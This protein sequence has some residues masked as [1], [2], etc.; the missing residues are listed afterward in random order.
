[1]KSHNVSNNDKQ[2]YQVVE[3]GVFINKR[4]KRN[5][6]AVMFDSI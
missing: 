5:D 6:K 3:G 1:M 4:D 2:N